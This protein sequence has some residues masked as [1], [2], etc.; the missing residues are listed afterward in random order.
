VRAHW[1]FK[2]LGTFS[3]SLINERDAGMWIRA[4]ILPLKMTIKYAFLC[5]LLSF[6]ILSQTTN[7]SGKSGLLKLFTQWLITYLTYCFRNLMQDKSG[8]N[9]N[10]A[11]KSNLSVQY[12]QRTLLLKSHWMWRQNCSNKIFQLAIL[13]AP[14]RSYRYGIAVSGS[15]SPTH[16]CLKLRALCAPPL[17]PSVISRGAP[18]QATWETSVSEGRNW[19]RKGRSILPPI[20]TST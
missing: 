17:V 11:W 14:L 1:N 8:A 16:L 18:R 13:L 2:T 5:R 7:I 10:F 3:V 9:M 19:A 12:K 20:P 6:V 4:S 15:T